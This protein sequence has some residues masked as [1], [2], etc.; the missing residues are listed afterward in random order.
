VTYFDQGTDTWSLEY[1]GPGGVSTTAGIVTKGNT[2]TWKK[3]IFFINDARFANGLTGGSDFRINSRGDG[4]EYI[5]MVMLAKRSGNP[6]LGVGLRAGAN[7]ISLPLAPGSTAIG[8]V[9]SS[10][11][12]QYTKVFAFDGATKSWKSFD[13]SLP[14]W[15]N[16]LQNIDATMGFW[17]YM[18]SDGMLNNVGSADAST[19]IELKNGANLIGFPRV[20]A[21]P[22]LSALSSIAGKYTKVFEYDATT[23]SWKSYDVSLPAW[24]NSLTEMRPGKAYWIYVNQDCT[25]TIVN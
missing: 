5:H 13:V 17:V 21:Q 18:D 22:I 1:D 25:L 15:A 10:I 3:H 8:D 2:N 19:N 14:A 11:A 9:L 20:N 24:A 4:D 6:E 7:L 12:G 23:M 16:T